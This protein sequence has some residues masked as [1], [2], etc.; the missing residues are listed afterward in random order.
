MKRF[1]LLLSAFMQFFL[2]SL[3]QNIEIDGIYYYLDEENKTAVVTYRGTSYNSYSD[4]YSGTVVIPETIN[5][6]SGNYN[7]TSI[8]ENAFYNCSGLTSVSIPNSVISI[9]PFAFYGTG[10]YNNSYNWENGVLYIDNCLIEVNENIES[11]SI[12]EGTRIISDNAFYGCS[13][14]TS[15][16]IP[17]S[18]I[19]IGEYSFYACSS[20]MS[21]EIP[22][23]VTSIGTGAFYYCR[24][25]YSIVI[26]ESVIFIGDKAFKECSGLVSLAIGNNVTSIGVDAFRDCSDLVFIT[27]G[28]SVISIGENAFYGTGMYN[29]SSNW[30]NGVL[31]INNCLI[32]AKEDICTEGFSIKEDTRIIADYA[33]KGCDFTTVTIPNSII[34]IGKN[35]FEYCYS[36]DFVTIGNNV[37]SI[38]EKAFGYCASLNSI[39]IPNSVTS[40]GHQ[41][42]FSCSKLLSVTIGNSVS[43]ISNSAFSDCRALIEFIVSSDNTNYSSE[44]GV[45]FNKDKTELILYPSGKKDKSYIIPNSVTHIGPNAFCDC[46]ALTSV[47]IGENVTSMFAYAFY[48]CESLTSVVWNA[49]NY[50]DLSYYIK[51]RTSP[52]HYIS[53]Q[54]SS[55]T[56]SNEVENIPAFLCNGM[57]N[58]KKITIPSSVTYIG[59]RAFEGCTGL[60][61][62][63]IGEGVK[64]IDYAAFDSC[65]KLMKI[66]AYP[67]TVPSVYMGVDIFE[68]YDATLYV[69]C[70]VLDQ[71][72][73]DSEWGRFK[74]IECINFDDSEEKD[75]ET[76]ILETLAD[77]NITVSNGMISAEDDFSIYNTVGQDVTALNGSLTPGVYVVKVADDIAKVMVQ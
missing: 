74:S 49:K 6:N 11:Y 43:S 54:I 59:Y 55:F 67:T 31:Y 38:G 14:L 53:S 42:F 57:S 77:A 58:I 35:A 36:L 27:I 47:T 23:S 25:L 10:I 20:L 13:N 4:E 33:L 68:N 21:I 64:E 63:V 28:D 40:I 75:E 12:K 50:E 69:P 15:V 61:E 70:D 72:S 2:V 37:V 29:N 76:A 51:N 62:V 41:A 9:R 1:L 48:R 30:D 34:S 44:T 32:K 26:P 3:A 65:D 16:Y 73:S 46:N 24:G 39:T 60:T 7:V 52:F 19:S 56:F 66:I 22:K 71:Y 5:Y 8:G 18:V 45:L 17:S